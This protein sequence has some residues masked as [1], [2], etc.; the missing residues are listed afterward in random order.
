MAAS[1]AQP[2]P[3][4]SVD[5]GVLVDGAESTR[6]RVHVVGGKTLGPVWLP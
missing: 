6:I 4:L 5:D 3:R 2:G 1:S